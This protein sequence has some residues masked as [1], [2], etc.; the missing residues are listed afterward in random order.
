MQHSPVEGIVRHSTVEGAEQ[1]RLST[2]QMAA[3][4]RHSTLT[5]TR[6]AQQSAERHLS[7]TTCWHT[8]N[9]L[10]NITPNNIP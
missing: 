7:P 6:T 3:T 10:I 8:P 1:Q 9:L 4:Y 5:R 2:I